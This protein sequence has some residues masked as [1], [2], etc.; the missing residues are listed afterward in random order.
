[1]NF[2]Y[3][4]NYI[5]TSKNYVYF[6]VAQLLTSAVIVIATFLHPKILENENILYVEFTLVLLIIFDLFLRILGEK[7]RFYDSTWN[8]IDLVLIVLIIILFSLFYLLEYHKGLSVSL[9]SDE[10]DLLGLI[11]LIIR[12]S[13]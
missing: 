3:Q 1:M 8:I 5:I 7:S 6:L 11:I 12:L 13:A 2:D 4:I 10:E 9:E